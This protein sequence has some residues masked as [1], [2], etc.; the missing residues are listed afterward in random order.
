MRSGIGKASACASATVVNAIATGKGAAFGVELRVRARAELIKGK[1]KIRGRII[2]GGGESARLIE[3]CARKVLEILG[4]ER[5]YGVRIE[6]DAGIPIA[7]G[8]SS[9][10]AAANAAVLAT[11]AAAGADPDMDRAL[12]LG[13]DA[14]LEA[15]VSVTGALDDAAA[16][17][18]GCG[19][20][21]HNLKRVI[22]RKFRI[23]TDLDVLVYIPPSKFYSSAVTPQSLAPI[24]KAVEI[25][26]DLAMRGRIMDAISLNGVLY[27]TALNQD[28]TPAIEAIAEGALGAGLTGTGSATVAIS[29]PNVSR[30]IEEMWK[31]RPGRVLRLKPSREGARVEP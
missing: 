4:M 17:M 28:P 2:G 29:E 19:V 9:S 24:R 11:Y 13:I 31:K 26:H 27:S 6:T 25:A 8:L 14:S 18:Y 16:S 22:L 1:G 23:R 12:E 5:E 10:S 15:G 3:I 7:V 30:R 20:V 21:T